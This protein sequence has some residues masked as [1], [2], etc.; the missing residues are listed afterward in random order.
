MDK[1]NLAPRRAV[2]ILP[3]GLLLSLVL[4]SCSSGTSPNQSTTSTTKSSGSATGGAASNAA[5][6]STTSST[7]TAGSSTTASGTVR[8][9]S[10][11]LSGS[12]AG[13]SAGA[14]TFELTIALKNTSS[15]PCATG[16]YPGLQ[17]VDSSGND[18]PTTT[19]RGGALSFEN[20][21][22]SSFTIP[23]GG[24]AWFNVGYSDV[25]TGTETTCPTA[26]SVQ[27]IPPNDTGHLVVSGI[28]ATVCN[29]GALD[30]S[31]LFGPGSPGTKTTA[32][33]S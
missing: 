25:P 15:S 26:S 23:S 32:P 2:A 24:T 21:A 19:N 14:G 11:G 7:S 29:D 9:V 28:N 22:P 8:C 31:P 1:P 13:S 10:S 6:T 20:V 4:A 16:G 18:L 17:L 33:P 30:T 3:A 5:G 27:V 12:L